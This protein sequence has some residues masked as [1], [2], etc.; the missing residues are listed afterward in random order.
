MI[1]VCRMPCRSVLVNDEAVGR[2]VDETIRLIQAFQ[3]ADKH[4]ETCPGDTQLHG[5]D[6]EKW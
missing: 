1:R 4:G 2:N 6:L 3:Y 5:T